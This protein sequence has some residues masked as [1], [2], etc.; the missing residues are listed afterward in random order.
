MIDITIERDLAGEG[1][2]DI[3]LNPHVTNALER[4]PAV[5]SQGFPAPPEEPGPDMGL[6]ALGVGVVI[7]AA[8]VVII[9][10]WKFK[11]GLLRRS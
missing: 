11:P 6:V 7:V 10:I 2:F 4:M 9:V 1:R 5:E 3:A 8:V